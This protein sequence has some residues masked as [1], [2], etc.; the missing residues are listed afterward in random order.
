MY[1]L[2]ISTTDGAPC[3][4]L[5]RSISAPGSQLDTMFHAWQQQAQKL[6]NGEISK[7]EYDEWRYKYPELDTS[8]RW[9]RIPSD[10]INEL[11]MEEF[12]KAEAKRKKKK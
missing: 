6:E 1:G 4:Y 8:Q 10:E 2:K 11:F 9:A 12:R 5:D 7:E 3:L